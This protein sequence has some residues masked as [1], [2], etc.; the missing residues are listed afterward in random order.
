M[1]E[2]K[3]MFPLISTEFCPLSAS[4]DPAYK[5]VFRYNNE[6]YTESLKNILKNIS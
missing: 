5:I 1:T 2:N 4:Q 6:H 3:N